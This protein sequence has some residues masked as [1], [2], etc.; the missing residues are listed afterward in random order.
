MRIAWLA[1]LRLADALAA[2]DAIIAAMEGMQAAKSFSEADL[3]S[4]N[5]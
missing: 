4:P 1:S 2:A 3:W 5:R